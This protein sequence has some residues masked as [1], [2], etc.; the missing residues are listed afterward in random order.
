MQQPEYIYNIFNQTFHSRTRTAVEQ[1]AVHV[2]SSLF[3]ASYVRFLIIY[4]VLLTGCVASYAT[5]IESSSSSSY[6][7][8][9]LHT[10]RILVRRSQ[11]RVVP[12]LHYITSL[13]KCVCVGATIVVLANTRASRTFL[14]ELQS[15]QVL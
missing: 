4:F 6:I 1:Q 8:C 7:I 3:S 13:C 11:I 10:F 15:N 9:V 12:L 5:R 14:K 2:S